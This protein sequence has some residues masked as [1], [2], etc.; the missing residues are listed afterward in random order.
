[1]FQKQVKIKSVYS[2]NHAKSMGIQFEPYGQLIS[3]E[4]YYG[5]KRIFRAKGKDNKFIQ[6]I[7]YLEALQDRV[8]NINQNI[9]QQGEFT[10]I[11]EF[12]DKSVGNIIPE[13]EFVL[14]PI[15]HLCKEISS[16]QIKYNSQLAISER[17]FKYLSVR[18]LRFYLSELVNL[19]LEIIVFR[20][21]YGYK[22]KDYA[23]K[24]WNKSSG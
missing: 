16:K 10:I 9:E 5:D 24:F 23:E 19:G 1:M 17:D 14:S 13:Y 3:Y 12:S 11:T 8:A 20:N 15:K 21:N 2:T 22:F 7:I 18:M 4:L 6:H